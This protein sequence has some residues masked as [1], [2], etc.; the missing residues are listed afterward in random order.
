MCTLIVRLAWLEAGMNLPVSH[1]EQL[2]LWLEV[3]LVLPFLQ[4]GRA[5]IRGKA[6]A[7]GSPNFPPDI[8]HGCDFPYFLL[9]WSVFFL[10]SFRVRETKCACVAGCHFRNC[11]YSG[12]WRWNRRILFYLINTKQRIECSSF[13]PINGRSGCWFI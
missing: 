2:S 13:S 8:L 7:L 10:S 5:P 6:T 11:F 1:W 9:N 4:W 3:P 12:G